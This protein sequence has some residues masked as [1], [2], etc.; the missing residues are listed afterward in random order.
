MLKLLLFLYNNNCE[1]FRG[2]G[3]L[4]C[5]IK[6]GF[7]NKSI[8]TISAKIGDWIRWFVYNGYLCIPV[9]NLICYLVPEMNLKCKINREILNIKNNILNGRN[10]YQASAWKI[11]FRCHF[12][13]AYID[14]LNYQHT[15]YSIACI[16]SDL[17]LCMPKC[18]KYQ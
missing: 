13:L 8:N 9:T 15:T 6:Y 16:F 18:T 4:I 1:L 17:F 12:L 11:Y 14:S 2:V 5:P 7:F 3:E 10:E